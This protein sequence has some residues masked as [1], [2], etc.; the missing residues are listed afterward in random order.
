VKTSLRG[1]LGV[2]AART[3]QADTRLGALWA[4]HDQGRCSDWRMSDTGD[5]ES[6]SSCLAQGSP[7]RVS[8]AD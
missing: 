2:G 4:A 6:I 5:D 8:D 3:D 1:G 7:E